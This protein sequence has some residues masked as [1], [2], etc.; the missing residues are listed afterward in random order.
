MSG[1]KPIALSAKARGDL[2]DIE[3]YTLENWDALQWEAYEATIANA[4]T[5]IGDNPAIGRE[6]DDIR[7]GYRSYVVGQHLIFY[8]ITPRAVVVI[9]ILPARKDHRRALRGRA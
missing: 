8:R 1:P 6:R 7:P 4:L 2:R 5:T 9:G 3:V